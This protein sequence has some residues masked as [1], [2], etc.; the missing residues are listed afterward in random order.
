[1]GC[2][3]VLLTGAHEE[4]GDVVNRWYGG[5]RVVSSRWPRLPGSYHGSGCT[6]A[7]AVAGYLALGLPIAEAMSEAQRFTWEALKNGMALGKGQFLPGR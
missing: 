2:A 7:S 1:M 5:G 4:G 6:L 3:N